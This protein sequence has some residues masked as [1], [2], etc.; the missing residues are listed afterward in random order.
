MPRLRKKRPKKRRPE[1]KEKKKMVKK[2]PKDPNDVDMTLEAV[3]KDIKFRNEN[4]RKLVD[5]SV[6]R[7]EVVLTYEEW[8]E[9]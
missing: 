9:S 6:G 8:R 4:N 3:L 1:R 7:E 5:Y 2:I